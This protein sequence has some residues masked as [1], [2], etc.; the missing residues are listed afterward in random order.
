[1][2]SPRE[3]LEREPL[4]AGEQL[5]AVLGNASE[6]KPIEAWER[7][8]GGS[9]SPIWAGSD[10]AAWDEVMPYA[11][12]VAVDSVFLEWIAEC[13]GD[14]WGWL[15][16]SSCPLQT[17]VE[18][19]RSLTK[20]LLPEGQAVF[21]RFWDGTYLLPVLQAL[22]AQGREVL[23]VFRRYWINGQAHEVGA[24]VAGPAQPSP[25][26]RVPEQVL[27]QLSDQSS[28]TLLD[29]LLQWLEEDRPELYAAFAPATLKQKV[30]YC[31][32]RPGF[33]QQALA[34]YLSSELS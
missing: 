27:K 14:D 12:V 5:F 18:H 15:A 28:V 33:S 22:G 23:P 34:A 7:A 10:Y 16:V 25:W 6:C 29:N 21:F 13:E 2:M 31:V 19:L 9:P 26:W 30:A 1:M 8:G 32:R 20:V 11:A 17:V 4:Q 24:A 3:W